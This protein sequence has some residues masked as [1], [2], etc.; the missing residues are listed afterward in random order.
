MDAVGESVVPGTETAKASAEAV[1]AVE[2]RCAVEEG[3]DPD[4]EVAF[5][6]D[7]ERF[8]IDPEDFDE[9]DLPEVDEMFAA[10]LVG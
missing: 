10:R 5:R 7:G 9:S 2:P 1:A 6:C 4:D 8:V 3:I